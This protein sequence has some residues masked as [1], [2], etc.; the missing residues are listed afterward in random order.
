MNNKSDTRQG[1]AF[2]A[3]VRGLDDTSKKDFLSILFY[4]PYSFSKIQS[5][6]HLQNQ[7]KIKISIPEERSPRS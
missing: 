2:R 5:I 3:L 4:Y 1:P 7:S 6:I